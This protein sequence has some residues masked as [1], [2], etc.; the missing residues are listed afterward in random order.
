MLNIHLKN[1][2][3]SKVL[4][5]IFE[6]EYITLPEFK[7]GT[8]FKGMDPTKEYTLEELGLK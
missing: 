1:W 6:I 2:G 8:M 3:C 4:N 5:T 7:K